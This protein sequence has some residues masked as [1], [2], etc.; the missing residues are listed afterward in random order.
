MAIKPF[1]RISTTNPDLSKVQ[2]SIVEVLSTLT[3]NEL[4]NSVVLHN[5]AITTGDTPI[6]HTLAKI[7]TGFFIVKSNADVRV[8]ESTTENTAK[9]RLIILRASTNATVSLILF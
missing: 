8:W 6:A 1:R 4:L 2:D 9:E 5:V 3:R 7:P